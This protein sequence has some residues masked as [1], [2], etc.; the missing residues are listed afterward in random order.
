MMAVL[1][2]VQWYF[3]VFLICISLI[4]NN[5]EQL[6][7]CFLAMCM[8]PLENCLFRYSG[9]FLIGLFICFDVELQEVFVY[10]GD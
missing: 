10:F 6:F 3:I 5:V 9:H 7:M 4:I 1:T 8:F 2:G